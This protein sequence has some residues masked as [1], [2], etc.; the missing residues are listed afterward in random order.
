MNDT[1]APAPCVRGC[2][3][4]GRHI[5]D[6]ADRDTCRGCFPRPAEFGQ[7]CESCHLRLAAM[8]QQAPAQRDL[9]LAVV[10]PSAQPSL[11]AQTIARIP[12]GWRIDDSHSRVRAHA[13]STS[14]APQEGEPLR[15]ACLDLAQA[16]ADTLSEWVERIVDETGARGPVQHQSND[17]RADS[18]RR[19][20]L[21]KGERA[22]Y[23]WT[24]APSRFEVHTASRW[25]IA[26]LATLENLPGIGDDFEAFAEEMSR[27]HAAAPWREESKRLRGIPCPECKR[28]SLRIFGGEDHVVCTT[29]KAEISHGRYLIWARMFEDARAEIE[30]AG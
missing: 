12:D 10:T 25:L 16:I 3:R 9:L 24:E 7:L 13:A 15:L 28:V 18:R 21:V 26:Q 1:I 22:G 20:A 8:I 23:R 14:S 2:T 11:T 30:E 19:V 29:C 6:C 5:T 17:A 4:Y 27:A